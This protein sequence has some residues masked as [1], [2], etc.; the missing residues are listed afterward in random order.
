M[1]YTRSIKNMYNGAN[2]Q[3]LTVGGNSEHF[4]VLMGWHHESTLNSFLFALMDVLMWKIQ[5]EVSWCMLNVND[6]ILIDK[7]CDR[8]GTKLKV[9][10]QNL[11][12]KG[13]RLSKT[14]IE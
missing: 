11:E 10:R 7:T 14:K 8:V 1:A 4:P 3:G 12:S 13:S 9:Q 2:T 6:V 5:S